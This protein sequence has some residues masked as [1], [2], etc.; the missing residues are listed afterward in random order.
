MRTQG[1]LFGSYL[2][3]LYYAFSQG[4]DIQQQGHAKAV[5]L[6]RQ[7][8]NDDSHGGKGFSVKPV[9]Q[10]EEPA[11]AILL[12][13][14]GGTGEEWG[15]ISLALSLISLNYVKFVIPSAKERRVTYLRSRMPSWF[16]IHVFD[17]TASVDKDELLESVERVKDIVKGEMKNGVKQERIFIVGFSQGG[18]LALTSFLRSP[19]KLGG[20]V[21]VATWLPLQKEYPAS[22]SSKIRNKDILMMHVS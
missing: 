3:L 4:I 16:D 22:R 20:C 2:L 7:K 9:L 14:L 21:G 11:T 5:S 8:V 15:Y 17:E 6:V 12:H 10:D 19:Y 18:A 1:L 13:G